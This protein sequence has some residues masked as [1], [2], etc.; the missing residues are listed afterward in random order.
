MTTIAGA[1][2]VPQEPTSVPELRAADR[3]VAR[4]LAGRPSSGPGIVDRS[5]GI[6]APAAC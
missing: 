1:P 2:I 4:Y 5:P 6:G 3:G